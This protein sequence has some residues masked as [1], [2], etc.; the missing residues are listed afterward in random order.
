MNV[1]IISNMYPSARNPGYGVFVK[2]FEDSLREQ[3]VLVSRV[4]IVGRAASKFRKILD[5]ILFFIQT[6][7]LVLFKRYDCVYVHYV[8]HSLLPVKFLMPILR[9][10]GTKLICNAHG[11]D[12]LPRSLVERLI[13]KFV[14]GLIDGGAL[15][16]VPSPYFADIARSKFPS[17][18]IFVSASGGVD[19]DV[20]KPKD[21]FDYSGSV[22]HL[23]YV[24]RI[25]PGKGWF[26]LLRAIKLIREQRPDI[27][28]K[29][30]F[31]GEG[32][33][34]DLLLDN[35]KS[36][37]MGEFVTYLG[38]MPQTMLPEFYASIDVFVFPTLLPESLGLVG[39]EAM[40]CGTPAICS[41]IGGVRGYVR[42]GINGYLFNP[43][44]S[45]DLAKCVMRFSQLQKGERLMLRN[46]AIET[47][48]EYGR[49]LVA[50]QLYAKL[51]EVMRK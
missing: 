5:Y 15:L 12:L 49:R 31:V 20:F 8:A 50:M 46:S 30:S 3:G 11:E 45:E 37:S 38:A 26:V 41:N 32:V 39:V 19:L 33:E 27:A 23:G 44:D 13:F 17:V 40:A 1:L 16:V 34:V 43:G 21:V 4:V 51:I 28:V 7:R 6:F 47:A 14:R 25:D 2:N 35:I 36:C 42:D 18:D 22:L 9:L 48:L 24:S 29:V 10:R